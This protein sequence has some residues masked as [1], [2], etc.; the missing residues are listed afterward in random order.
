MADTT[1]APVISGTI[2]QKFFLTPLNGPDNPSNYLDNF[3]IEVYNKSIDSHLVKFMYSLMGPSGL[4][5]IQKN[6]L[7]ARLLLEDYGIEG[8][9]LDK[10]YGD[11]LRFGRILEETY[12]RDLSGLISRE[13]WAEIKAKDA[14]YRSRA[15]NYIAGIRAGTTP[16]G[17]ELV[18]KSGLGHDASIT[19]NYRYLYDQHSDDPLGLE[20]RGRTLSAEEM[21]V[22]PR[23]EVPQS[24]V[25]KIQFVG[26]VTGGFF[27]LFM[28]VG[29]PSEQGTQPIA[30]DAP[31][32]IV[33]IALESLPSIG[34]GNILVE[35]GPLPKEPITVRYVGQ[36]SYKDLPELQVDMGDMIGDVSM[37]AIVTTEVQGFTN[38]NQATSIAVRDQRYL[39]TALDYTKPVTTIVTFGSESGSKVAQP[40]TGT[41]S[42]SS[43][44]NEVVR[45]VTGRSDIRWPART[46]K[47]WVEAGVERK[48]LRAYDDLQ[49]HY[50]GFHNVTRAQ[51]YGEDALSDPKYATDGWSEDLLKYR[52]EHV[53]NFT[54]L[55]RFLYGHLNA[56][57][58]GYSTFVASNGIAL[59]SEPLATTS[60]NTSEDGTPTQLVN[61][62]Y[63]AEYLKLP[64]VS[65][66]TDNGSRFWASKQRT[67]G[68]DYLEIDLGSVQAINYLTFEI[69]NKPCDIEINYDAL[70]SGNSRTF[71]PVVHDPNFNTS[72]T[73]LYEP[74]RQNP[75][76]AVEF[77][78][79]N[80][81]GGLVFSRYLRIKLTRR[82][83]V[84]SPFLNENGTTAEHSL[85][86]K[87]L[88]VGRNI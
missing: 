24:E 79:G 48:A 82:V 9:E 57:F 5:W 21:I 65:P 71:I 17:M 49:Y 37:N 43:E 42:V 30:F 35:G 10:F 2:D 44:Y 63:P 61:G 70:D 26:E 51:A 16:L 62:I 66:A 54:N 76:R 87:N 75:W 6:Y 8:F 52:S 23:Q 15:L 68:S 77:L 36:L 25:Q 31:P 19:E 11:P 33:Q 72:T 12:E 86:I 4:G 47:Y 45:Y 7:E 13:K 40:W 1:T 59:Y 18:S 27:R 64:G 39:L 38:S 50:Q 32:D 67:E 69:S 29:D 3:P 53:G 46:N 34:K 88:R 20:Y 85:E 78:F 81:Q 60:S 56:E 28:P 83:G 22:A 58:T 73:I 74:A 80:Q 41:P 55:Q 84:G 14:K